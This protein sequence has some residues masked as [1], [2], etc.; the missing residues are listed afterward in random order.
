MQ[1]HTR[2]PLTYGGCLGT[3][4]IVMQDKYWQLELKLSK[5]PWCVENFSAAVS[6]LQT[7]VAREG[8]CCGSGMCNV[9]R[10]L[11]EEITI[12]SQ[13]N[14]HLYLLEISCIF[15][16]FSDGFQCPQTSSQL[17]MSPKGKVEDYVHPFLCNWLLLLTDITTYI[18]L[19]FL[20]SLTTIS[21]GLG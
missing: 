20:L 13:V 16:E 15:C 12:K 2:P 18:Q 9:Q 5:V 1:P 19:H 14:V 7:A 10:S 8:I 4:Q 11:N 6:A 3:R 17:D 21:F